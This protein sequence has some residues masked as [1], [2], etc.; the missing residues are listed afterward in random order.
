MKQNAN[1]DG[2]STHQSNGHATPAQQSQHQATIDKA[3][4]QS[5]QQGSG[6]DPDGD[7]D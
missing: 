6:S 1:H 4:Q 3:H 2:G 5:Q 7:G